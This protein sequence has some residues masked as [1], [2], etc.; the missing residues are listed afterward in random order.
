MSIDVG[1]IGDFAEGT[2]RIVRAAGREIGIVRWAGAIYALN[3]RCSHQSG[4]VCTGILGPRLTGTRPGAMELDAATPVLAC[5]WH[6]WEFDVRTGHAL[7][8]GQHSLRTFPARIAGDRVLVELSHAR[9]EAP[10]ATS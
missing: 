10:G 6:G 3:N 4:P 5:P 8:D 1:P 9:T 7:H 2:V